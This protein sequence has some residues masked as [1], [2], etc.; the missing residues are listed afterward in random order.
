MTETVPPAFKIGNWVEEAFWESVGQNRPKKTNS[1][2]ASFSRSMRFSYDHRDEIDRML[3]D[4]RNQGHPCRVHD[5]AG[6]WLE[7]DR[8][9]DPL[10]IYF[11][12]GKPE[13][14]SHGGN[15][16]VDTGTLLAGG[17]KQLD[18]QLVSLLYRD[19][20]ALP[21]PNPLEA[22]G[23]AAVAHTLRIMMNEGV[24]AWIEDMPNTSFSS[25]HPR[26]GK[27][28]FIPETVFE[29]GIRAMDIFNTNLPRLLADPAAMTK[30]GS[31]LAR[32]ITGAG[33]LTQ[34]GYCMAAVIAGRLGE[35]KL[36]EVRLSPPAFLAAYQEAARQNTLPLP[37]PGAAGRELYETMPALSGEVFPGLLKLLEDS[38]PTP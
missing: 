26:L 2:R 18:R 19:R 28:N 6:Q 29:T 9:P 15:L 35:Q 14:R 12:A 38:F 13:L 27:V 7:K 22:Q 3:A 34:G 4:Y 24:A 8:L 5:L 1:D 20:Q 32:A 30:N 10:V 21:G 23:S 17:S 36:H 31:N 16:V 37:H 25:V 11:V 33:A